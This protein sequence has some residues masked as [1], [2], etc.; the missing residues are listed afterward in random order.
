VWL[1]VTSPDPL[2]QPDWGFAVLVCSMLFGAGGL[3]VSMLHLARNE[4]E[5]VLGLMCATVNTVAM[6]SPMIWMAAR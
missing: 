3:L 5:R 2:R 1:L 4:S 6:A